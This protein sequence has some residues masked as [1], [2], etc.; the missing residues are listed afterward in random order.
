MIEKSIVKILLL[1]CSIFSF[2]GYIG[3]IDKYFLYIISLITFV[4][5]IFF[6]KIKDIYISWGDLFWELLIVYYIFSF[7][8][9]KEIIT[10]IKFVFV[11]Q[12]YC[13]IKII[14]SNKLNWQKEWILLLTMFSSVHV[15]GTFLQA[16]FPSIIDRIALRILDSNQLFIRSDLSMNNLYAGITGQTGSNAFFIVIF[17]CV[18]L[19]AALVKKDKRIV[20]GIFAFFGFWMLTFT[21]KRGALVG[22]LCGMIVVFFTYYK[23][24]W[25]NILKILGIGA[26]IASILIISYKFLPTV[27]F[28]FDRLLNTTGDYTSGR[29]DIYAI[30][31]Q[32]A[33]NSPIL[34]NGIGSTAIYLSRSIVGTGHN[35]YL[36]TLSESGVIGLGLLL[37]CFGYYFF[38]T[39]KTLRKTIDFKNDSK[40]LYLLV[41]LFFQ[42]VFLVMGLTGNTYFDNTQLLVYMIMVSIPISL[43]REASHLY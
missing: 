7:L 39:I 36:Q 28:I 33:I 21:G 31:W 16:F 19:C 32:Q 13:I 12:L 17:I 9:A 34:G 35:I 24:S 41:S 15:I 22:V 40:I 43:K 8:Y 4:I 38:I 26:L 37:L 18:F 3:F 14:I 1:F 2:W 10:S 30:L 25:K 6:I 5:I 29:E 20:T 42:T 27:T 23:K 11:L